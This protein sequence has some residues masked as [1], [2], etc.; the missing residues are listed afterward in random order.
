MV[1]LENVQ[2]KIGDELATLQAELPVPSRVTVLEHAKAP[3]AKKRD[4]QMKVAAGAFVALFGLVF[5]AIAMWEFRARRVYHSDEV[6][7]GLGLNL[8]GTLPPLPIQVRQI[9]VGAAPEHGAMVEAVDG[10]RTRLLH[11][12]RDGS[13]RVLMIASAVGGEG[14]TSL[15]SQLAASLARGGRKTLLVDCDLRNPGAPPPFPGPPGSRLLRGPPWRGHL[16]GPHPADVR[17]K[18]VAA[19]GR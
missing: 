11:A 13:V 12:A 7:Q 10:V 9:G 2:K 16:R 1:Q 14:K 19:G 5:M 4:R 3:L 15:A 8:L 6:A 18:P 17:G